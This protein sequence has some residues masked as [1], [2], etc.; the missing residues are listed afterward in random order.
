MTLFDTLQAA[1]LPVVSAD[2]SGALTMGPMTEAQQSQLAE[3]LLQYFQPQAY[4]DLQASHADKQGF[5]DNYLTMINRLEQ[6]QA[7]SSPTN[8]QVI[9]AIKDL[10]LYIERIMKVAKSLT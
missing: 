9:Q 2:E 8:A 6:I 5:K 4:Q 1:G 7:V 10:A 3:I